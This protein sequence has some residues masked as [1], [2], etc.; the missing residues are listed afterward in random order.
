[1]DL[2]RNICD[3]IKEWELKIGYCRQDMELYY[4]ESSLIELTGVEKGEL[5]EVL[6]CFCKSVKKRLGALVIYET[7][8]KGRYCIHVPAEGVEYVHNEIKGSPFLPCFLKIIKA[9][10][11]T[12]TD[13]ETIFRSF[14]KNIIIEKKNEFEW[15]F[16]FSDANIDPYVY[17][18]EQDEFGLQYHR[19]TKASYEA[20]FL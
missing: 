1:M 17:F 15:A 8:E 12:L 9:H 20:L 10:S 19:F 4:P 11:A 14:D 16:R 18:V 2:E 6:E 7:R 13:A 5:K 3:T